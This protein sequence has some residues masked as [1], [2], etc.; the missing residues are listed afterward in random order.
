MV[1]ANGLREDC[2]YMQVEHS[3]KGFEM[4]GVD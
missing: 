3:V 1:A 4:V 2:E